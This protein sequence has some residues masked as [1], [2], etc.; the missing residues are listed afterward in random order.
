MASKMQQ[1]RDY[2]S[3]TLMLLARLGYATT[4]Q[5]AMAIWGSCNLSNRKMAGRTIRWLIQRG[6]VVEKRDGDSVAGERMVALTRAGA[7][8]LAEV[9]PLPGNR[10]HARDWLPTQ[11]GLT[12]HPQLHLGVLLVP[13]EV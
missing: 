9:M 7:A 11:H 10:S 5:V 12:H 6:Y 3:K 4:R 1:G 8:L 2:R 13:A